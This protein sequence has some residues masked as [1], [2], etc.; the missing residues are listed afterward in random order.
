M[1]NS[2][3]LNVCV[4]LFLGLCALSSGRNK[5]VKPY[6]FLF[7]IA[8]DQSFPHAG[9][10][11][12]KFFHTPTFDS[13]ARAGVHFTRAFAAAP[14]CSPSRAALLTGKNIWQLEEAGTHGSYFPAKFE[15]FTEVLRK[16]GYR[17]GYTGKAWDPGNWKDAGWKTNPV[18]TEY[19][20][21]KLNP[22]ISKDLSD[23]DYAAN[24][25]VFLN[26]NE[27]DAPFF[28][29]FGAHEP[30]RTYTFG[31]GT[32]SSEEKIALPAF[33]PRTDT[34]EQDFLDYAR[35][36]QYFDQQLGRM[37]QILADK[38]VL[39]RT[40]II[41]TADNGM[42]FPHAKASLHEFGIHVPLLIAGPTIN[43]PGRANHSLV[44]LID[45]PNTILTLA[46]AEK[47]KDGVGNNLVSL[48]SSEKKSLQKPVFSGRERHTHARPDNV[49]YPSRAIR[50]TQFLYVKN[51]KPERWPAGDP[52]PTPDAKGIVGYEDIDDSPT[53]RQMM[54]RADRWPELFQ[55]GFGKKP[56][57]ELYDMRKDPGCLVD[58]SGQSAY[59][60]IKRKLRKELENTLRQQ[61][62]PRI[63]GSG[64]IFETYPRF[65][66]MR[67][68]PGFNIQ[69][70]YHTDYLSPQK[71]KE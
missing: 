19:N 30:H 41:V 7:A 59:G 34:V 17:T 31:S 71:N 22:R 25:E 69:G 45:L 13:L 37:I 5:A 27:E 65:G 53:K 3:I 52:A 44:S 64:D 18:G 16:S 43:R 38:G 1:V 15:V 35:E 68:F 47:L 60:A 57:E 24:L 29:W 32:K 61:Q 9:I 54:E 62:D 8:D 40:Y 63:T 33:L 39:D 50:T 12:P 20:A 42:A 55:A 58:L 26:E 56:E 2:G 6:H 36:I 4:G 21:K 66:K 28:F 48:L 11:Q 70:K 51:F 49:G 14:Q 10:Y 23:I 67:P 46:N